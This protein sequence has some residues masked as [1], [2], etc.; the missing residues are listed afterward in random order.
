[1]APTAAA[2]AAGAATG[3][4]LTAQSGM[5]GAEDDAQRP[6]APAVILE[7]ARRLGWIEVN[8]A[9]LA[10]RPRRRRNPLRST[11]A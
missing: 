9:A 2:P 7:H 10:A 4:S 6:F 5:G 1:M 11:M 8:R 3:S